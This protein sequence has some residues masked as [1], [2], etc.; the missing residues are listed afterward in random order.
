MN[1]FMRVFFLPRLASMFMGLLGVLCLVFFLIHLIP[2]DPIEVMLGESALPADKEAL[3]HNLGLDLP[4]HLQWWHYINHLLQWDLGSSLLSGRP[5]LDLIWE[6][7]PST[8]Y[9]SLASLGVAITLAL[10]LGL[11]AATHKHQVLDAATMGFALLGLS[12]PNFW[13]GPLLILGGS[14]WLGWFPVSGQEGWN[15]VMLPA[16]TLGTSMAAILARMIRSS[17]LETMGEDFLRTAQAKGL[18]PRRILFC[19]ALPNSLLPILTLLGLQL[20]GLLGGAV[21]TETVFSWPGLG[22]LMIEAIQ[23]RDYP[24]VQAAVLCISVAYILVNF[25]TDVL[26]AWLDPRIQFKSP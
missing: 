4:L 11:L 8:L 6:R 12:I 24:V 19:H 16:I 20:G 25:L 22:L 17:L 26:Y 3:R 2:G 9:L 7:I 5:I 18:S 10:P 23:Q 14:L 15:A 1:H 21:I 13:L